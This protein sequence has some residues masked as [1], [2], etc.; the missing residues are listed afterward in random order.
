MSTG[1]K[2]IA[3]KPTSALFFPRCNLVFP[4]PVRLIGPCCGETKTGQIIIKIIGLG[5]KQ[6]L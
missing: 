6:K 4:E 3:E 2:Y 1:R 5:E